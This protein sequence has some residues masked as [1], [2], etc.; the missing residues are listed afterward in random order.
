MQ[1][2]VA[3]AH[4]SICLSVSHA[5]I[6]LWLKESAQIM[7]SSLS[8]SPIILVFGA[9]TIDNCSSTVFPACMQWALL[10]EP[11]WCNKI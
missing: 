10:V 6:Q 5:G 11:Y 8:D 9:V 1:C 7:R 3:I 2:S 4:P